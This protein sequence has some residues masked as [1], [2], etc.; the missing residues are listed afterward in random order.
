MDFDKIL[1]I[2]WGLY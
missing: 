2:I 1:F